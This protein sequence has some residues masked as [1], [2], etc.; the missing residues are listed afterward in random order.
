MSVR[1]ARALSALVFGSALA[2]SGCAALVGRFVA[3]IEAVVLL[4]SVCSSAI[5]KRVIAPVPG[6]MAATTTLRSV[7]LR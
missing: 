5:P 1:L 3:T 6:Q 7:T 4:N 2:G